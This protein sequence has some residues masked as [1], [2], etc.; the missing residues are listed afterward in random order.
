[1]NLLEAL[2]FCMEGTAVKAKHWVRGKV[3]YTND[4]TNPIF[5]GDRFYFEDGKKFIPMSFND[6]DDLFGEWEVVKE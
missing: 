6:P 3:I 1:M 4:P 2:Q 5:P